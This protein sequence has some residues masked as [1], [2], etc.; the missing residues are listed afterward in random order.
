M[1]SIVVHIGMTAIAASCLSLN[2]PSQSPFSDFFSKFETAVM[3]GNTSQLHNLMAHEF[4]YI[5]ST[6]A[7]P[8]E[9]FKGLS[10]GQ[11]LNLQS[12]VQAEAFTSQPYKDKPARLLKM[13]ACDYLQQV[14]CGLSN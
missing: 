9:V 11:W 4:D 6:N 3:A 8:S 1:K 7:T 5:G 2:M 13:H 12:A 10:S 14:L